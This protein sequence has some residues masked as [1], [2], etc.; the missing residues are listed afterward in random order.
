MAR[1][2]TR[3]KALQALRLEVPQ[4]VEVATDGSSIGNPG[5]SGAG[6]VLR[7]VNC[8]EDGRLVHRSISIGHSTNNHELIALSEALG[9]CLANSHPEGVCIIS[10]ADN[11]NALNVA[12]GVSA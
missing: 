3:I 12:K 8:G 2:R 4:R 6:F 1:A 5:P 7:D 10:L 11:L 9:Y